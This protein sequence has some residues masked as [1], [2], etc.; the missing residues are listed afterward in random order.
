[1]TKDPPP[2]VGAYMITKSVPNREYVLEKNPNFAAARIP[3]VPEAKINTITT[4]IMPNARP[5]DRGRDQQQL[6]YMQDPPAADLKAEVIERFG[7]DGT[8]EQRY[9][10]SPTLSTYFFF[11][12]NTIPPFDDPKV[13]EA[14][15]V[16]VDKTALARLYAG[17]LA[18]RLLVPAPGYA[19]ATANPSTSRIARGETRTS[20]PTSSVP[21]S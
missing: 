15:N 6:D 4:K 3:D 16:G 7:P 13:R 17:A 12:N 8:E 21:S 1:M 9:K 19:R 5:A 2:G 20:R 14:V 18:A 10:E 11:L